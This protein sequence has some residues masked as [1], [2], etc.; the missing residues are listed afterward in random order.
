MSRIDQAAISTQQ[1]ARGRTRAELLADLSELT[2]P[3]ITK[4]VVITAGVGFAMAAMGRSWGLWELIGAGATCLLGTALSASGANALNQWMERVRDGRMRR[5]SRRPIPAG[6]LS[7]RAGLIVGLACAAAGVGALLAFNNAAAAAVSAA[8]I[9]IYLLAYTTL[10]PVTPLATIIGAIPG[11]LPPLIGWCAA[12]GW[13][14]AGWAGGGAA[15]VTGWTL[16][17]HPGG[18]ALFMIMFIWQI[19]H[20]LAIAWMHREDYARGG[21]K[22]LP[23]VDADGSRT[24]TA[25]LFWAIALIPVSLMAAPMMPAPP[26]VAYTVVAL[27]GGLGF[28][29]AGVRFFQRRDDASARRLFLASILYLPLLLLVMVADAAI[30]MSL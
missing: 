18:W 27:V 7:S 21:H 17:A 5:T 12:A 16:L 13:A 20:F 11:A 24:T 3:G 15:E 1:L 6:R 2:K 14:G 28:A 26:G 19:P 29:W 23:V 9:I 22:V 4:M 25:A 30:A 10:K 8:T